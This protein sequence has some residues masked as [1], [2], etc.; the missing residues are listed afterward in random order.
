V[1]AQRP[2]LTRE[3]IETVG[4]LLRAMDQRKANSARA[5]NSTADKQG[6]EGR[7]RQ[8]G[9]KSNDAAPAALAAFKMRVGRRRCAFRAGQSPPS[10]PMW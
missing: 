2:E 8:V 6:R 4:A 5:R 9:G 3:Q 7:A 1:C 10:L